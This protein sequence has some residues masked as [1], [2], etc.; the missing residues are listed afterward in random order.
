M[1]RQPLAPNEHS[2]NNLKCNTADLNQDMR[3]RLFSFSVSDTR[4]APDHPDLEPE[5]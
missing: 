5:V 1:N 2:S 3:R 4:V